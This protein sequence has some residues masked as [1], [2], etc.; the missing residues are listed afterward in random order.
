MQYDLHTRPINVLANGVRVTPGN[1]GFG[2]GT[3]TWPT[4]IAQTT[5]SPTVLDILQ[6]GW[7]IKMNRVVDIYEHTELRAFPAD[8]AGELEVLDRDARTRA[9]AL[10]HA[11]A[12]GVHGKLIHSCRCGAP[13]TFVVVAIARALVPDHM[14]IA[15]VQYAINVLQCVRLACTIVSHAHVSQ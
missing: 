7:F 15:C 5:T 9:R 10:G 1:R 3:G 2:G 11:R 12:C 14:Q 8:A 13:E 6:I 4:T